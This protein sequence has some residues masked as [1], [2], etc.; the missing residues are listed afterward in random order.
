MSHSGADG[1]P[2]ADRLL[3][4]NF[5]LVCLASLTHN[6]SFH[7]LLAALPLY[8]LQMGGHETEVGMLMAIAAGAALLMRP[9]SGWAVGAMGRK[10]T[11]LLGTAAFAIASTAYAFAGSLFTLLAFRILH[12]LGIGTFS[13]GAPTLIGDQTPATRRGE[14]MGY[15]GVSMTLAQAI[16]PGIG[17]FVAERWGFDYL[18]G[19]SAGLA[20]TALAFSALV[21]D[22]YRP[23]PRMRPT[24]NMFINFKALRPLLL[25][26]GMAFATGSIVSFVP[27]YGRAEGVNNPGFFFTV[28]AAIIMVSRPLSGRL[29]DRRGRIAVTIPAIFLISAGLGLLA[30]S[31]QW[32]SLLVSALI[33]G[34]GIGTAYP[35]L[36]A[37]MIDMVPPEER[38]G[39]MSTYGIGLDVGMCLGSVVQGMA[40]EFWGFGTAFGLSAAL[41]LFTMAVYWATGRLSPRVTR[42]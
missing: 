33:L 37:L 29:S 11:M 35:A 7:V 13:T 10:K 34:I 27:L 12:G 8:V 18:F 15:F 41:P 26:F 24:W 38:G 9:F 31:G 40:V 32:W 36:M 3:T 4:R 28:Y 22:H 19:L 23:Q 21:K 14:A 17:L 6:T 5:V 16:G 20:L 39:A 2:T 30:F 42:E 1:S 25:V